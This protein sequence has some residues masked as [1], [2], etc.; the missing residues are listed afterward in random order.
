MMPRTDSSGPARAGSPD[1]STWAGSYPAPVSSRQAAS[2]VMRS[3]DTVLVREAPGER[4]Q[5]ERQELIT[6]LAGPG[7]A[8]RAGD[9]LVVHPAFG[10]LA[11]QVEPPRRGAGPA[12]GAGPGQVDLAEVAVELRAG[13]AQQAGDQRRAEAPGALDPLLVTPGQRADGRAHPHDL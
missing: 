9:L 11:G 12:D 13:P 5:H 6:R 10:E 1:S 2:P 3:R 7:W 8:D 4:A